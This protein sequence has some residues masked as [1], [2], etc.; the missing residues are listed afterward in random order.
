MDVLNLKG[1]SI[2][3]LARLTGLSAAWVLVCLSAVGCC[4]KQEKQIIQLTR[5]C[6]DLQ[7]K[8][9]ALQEQLGGA[10][11]GREDLLSQIRGQNLQLAAKD[12]QIDRLKK[13][14]QDAGQKPA[15][16]GGKTATGW[17]KGLAGDK[18]TVGSD[19]LFASGQATLTKAGKAALNKIA[20]DLKSTYAGLPV[21]VYGFTDNDP[22][23]KTR[24]LWADNLD[25]SANRAMAVTRYL[26]RMGI[27]AETIETIGMGATRFVTSNATKAGKAK[28]RRVEIIVLK[29]R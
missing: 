21:R 25:L 24:K 10:D 14:L 6:N 7:V 2:M 19:I 11:R 27:K 4:E 16:N 13:D 18:V 20:R 15:S 23:R 1:V 8:N 22:I 3:K 17:E 29:K 12:I 5:S 9:K 26:I 28:N